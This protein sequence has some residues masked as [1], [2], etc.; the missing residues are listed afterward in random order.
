[1]S[2]VRRGQV[3][4]VALSGSVQAGNGGHYKEGECEVASAVQVR[5]TGTVFQRA[6]LVQA[7]FGRER[8]DPEAGGP[9]KMKEE[10]SL[11]KYIL[12]LVI[13]TVG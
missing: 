4:A 1:M 3:E 12:I 9:R 8:L 10:R 13:M 6:V 2:H 7:R 5:D 11:G